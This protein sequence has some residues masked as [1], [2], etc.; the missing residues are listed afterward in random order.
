MATKVLFVVTSLLSATG[1]VATRTVA[2]PTPAQLAFQDQ[3][4]SMFMHFGLCTFAACEHNDG[5]PAAHP[6]SL[7]NPSNLDTDQ[8]ARAAVA[9]G[10]KEIC[11]TA[12]HE[13]GFALWPS[14]VTNYSV[15]ASPWKQGKGDVIKSFVDSCRRHDIKPCFYLAPP[16]NGY[17][18]RQKPPPDVYMAQISK[19]LTELLTN[20]G[21]IHRLWFDH[22]CTARPDGPYAHGNSNNGTQYFHWVNLIRSLS[23]STL[24]LPGP[25]GTLADVGEIN[26]GVYPL[27]NS[28]DVPTAPAGQQFMCN[29][30]PG[31]TPCAKGPGKPQWLPVESD[32]T[33]QGCPLCS[34]H[35]WFWAGPPKK[36]P[37]DGLRVLT[38]RELWDKYLRTV[39][40]GINMIM[41]VP[42]NQTGQI[43]EEFLRPISA[44]GAAI[45][46]TFFS[47]NRTV[48][49]AR[50]VTLTCGSSVGVGS[51]NSVVLNFSRLERPALFDTLVSMEDLTEGQQI[52]EYALDMF[53]KGQQSGT[54]WQTVPCEGKTVG[55]KVVDI[56]AFPVPTTPVPSSVEAVRFTCLASGVGGAAQAPVRLRRFAAVLAQPPS[57]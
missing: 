5:N 34:Q 9:M 16:H 3:E 2:K 56:M 39:G 33:I 45:N 7:F 4:L 49:E 54:S 17:L 6:P 10:A 19:I 13:G 40:R 43:A 52:A 18:L 8:W 23:R 14:K 29:P 55:H 12:F 47:P 24:V 22:W 51:S 11:L 32:G 57:E 35:Q 31:C 1:I 20:Y 44:F 36:P 38:A 53:V 46:A 42:P 26:P 48:L 15:A 41:N 21:P 28:V 30:N 25:D 37:K 50:N 27:W